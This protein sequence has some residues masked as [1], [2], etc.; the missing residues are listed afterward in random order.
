[1]EL[2]RFATG[3]VYI[4]HQDDPQVDHHPA[5]LTYLARKELKEAKEHIDPIDVAKP[6]LVMKDYELHHI[7]KAVHELLGAQAAAQ[8]LV[9]NQT[10]AI[11]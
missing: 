2:H 4:P 3:G 6:V 10:C 1:M 9:I 11:P 7:E 5:A 8:T